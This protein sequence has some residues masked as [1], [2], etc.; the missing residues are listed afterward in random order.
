MLKKLR[1]IADRA[2]AAA[3]CYVLMLGARGANAQSTGQDVGT[4]ADN[5][6]RQLGPL[7][8]FI[9][10]AC[11]LLGLATGIVS[12]LKFKAHSQ[13]PNDPSAKLST[14]TM[15]LIAAAAL[16]GIP[17]VLGIGVTSLFGSGASTVGTDSTLRSLN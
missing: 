9:G 5:L 14:A 15:Y 4:V 16:I 8:D 3:T 10:A 1:H 6:K 13:N 11:F 2:A 12:L 7:A 17:Q